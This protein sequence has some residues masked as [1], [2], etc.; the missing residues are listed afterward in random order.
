MLHKNVYFM[1]DY[2]FICLSDFFYSNINKIL[3]Y[4]LTITE[5][6]CRKIPFIEKGIQLTQ[7]TLFK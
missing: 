1:E 6:I 2:T 7:H 3:D 4:F 5:Q